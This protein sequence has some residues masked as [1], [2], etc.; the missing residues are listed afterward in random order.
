MAAKASHATRKIGDDALEIVTTFRAPPA[1]VFRMWSQ[2][3]HFVR[4]Y[5][6]EGFR[7]TEVDLDFRVGGKW[8]AAMV[9]PDGTEYRM[10]G[11]Y[12]EIVA[13]K[14][15]VMTF[16][17]KRADPPN[18]VETVIVIELET[19][20]ANTIQRFH[21]SGFTDVPMRDS[22]IEGWSSAFNKL[23]AHTEADAAQK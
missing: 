16:A 12:R 14:R 9:G 19:S 7:C 20:G 4:W 15:I 3:Q 17:G 10:G 13:D 1:L 6:P 18:A 21:Q 2:P 8:S 22:H 11:A 23:L 5:G